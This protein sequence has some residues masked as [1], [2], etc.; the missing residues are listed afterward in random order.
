MADAAYIESL[1][2]W[3]SRMDDEIRGERGLLALGGLYWLEAGINT[4]GSSPDCTI[5]LPKPIPRLLGAFEFDGSR[6]KFHADVGQTVEVNGVTMQSAAD[7]QYEDEPGASTVRRDDVALALTRHAG[8]VGVR[9]WNAGRA[10]AFP[11]RSWF[12][13]NLDYKI[14]GSYTGYPA[15][16]KIKIPDSLGETQVGYVQGYL[17]FKL[18]GKSHSLDAAETDD[19]R[20]FLQF[21][22]LTSGS[23]TYAGGRYLET[24]PVSEDGLV[25]LDF[26]RAHNP[27]SAF[28]E[29]APCSLAPKANTLNCAVEAGERHQVPG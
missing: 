1:Q 23:T 15:P 29:F 13:P 14:Q 17:T 25:S 2:A 6:V 11:P 20:L 28:S 4:V 19:G 22:D 5:C 24:E 8:R 18:G 10:Q 12:D 27:P 3:R 7:L 26:N 16:V 21:K 9:L